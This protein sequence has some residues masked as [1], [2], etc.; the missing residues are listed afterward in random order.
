M[1]LRTQIAFFACESAVARKPAATT[2]QISIFLCLLVSDTCIHGLDLFTVLI[3]SNV[4]HI[5]GER[6]PLSEYNTE[7]WC[8]SWTF[9]RCTSC[10]KSLPVLILRVL[11]SFVNSKTIHQLLTKREDMNCCTSSMATARMETT[12][13]PTY[14][15]TRAIW[16][17]TWQRGF[18][19]R[20]HCLRCHYSPLTVEVSGHM[21]RP[22]QWPH[23]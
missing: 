5:I 2:V 10:H 19:C 15:M 20:C 1:H 3:Q 22:L 21:D 9:N 4:L 8:L 14:S 12:R 11:A 17:T 18:I 16:A 7:I 13:G 23:R 6:A